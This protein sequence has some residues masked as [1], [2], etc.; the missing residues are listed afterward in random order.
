MKFTD[1]LRQLQMKILKNIWLF[2]GGVFFFGECWM[3]LERIHCEQEI[4]FN[5]YLVENIYVYFI[6]NIF[7]ISLQFIQVYSWFRGK[8]N[9]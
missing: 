9:N 6:L 2:V 1:I 7:A 3:P 4:R 8:K 5:F